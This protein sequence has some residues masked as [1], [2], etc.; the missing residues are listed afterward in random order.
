MAKNARNKPAA[1]EFIKWA[2]SQSVLLELALRTPYV[3]SPRRSTVQDTRYQQKNN[4][5]E[6]QYLPVVRQ[7]LEERSPVYTPPIPEWGE[8]GDT[9]SS[10]I[11][12][13]TIGRQSA[14]DAMKQAE[15]EVDRILKQAG[16]YR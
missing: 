14:A 2:T 11:S 4:L 12:R 3:A 13:V 8:V 9:I 6:G 10:A 1:W 16:Y 15:G 5:A 7:M